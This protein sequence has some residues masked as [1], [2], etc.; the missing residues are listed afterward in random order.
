MCEVCGCLIAN[1]KAVK[2]GSVVRVRN[3]ENPYLKTAEEYIYTPYYC[4]VHTPAPRDKQ[5]EG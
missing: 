3:I 2:G 5:M 1:G 4:L